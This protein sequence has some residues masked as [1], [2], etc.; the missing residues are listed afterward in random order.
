MSNQ[1]KGGLLLQS[2]ELLDFINHN[3]V[4]IRLLRDMLNKYLIGV[5]F[6]RP[7]ESNVNDVELNFHRVYLF[8][9]TLKARVPELVTKL[10][11]SFADG[12]ECHHN[13]CYFEFEQDLNRRNNRFSFGFVTKSALQLITVGS[14]DSE[15]K[16]MISGTV[17]DFGQGYGFQ[18]DQ[19]TLKLEP[20]PETFSFNLDAINSSSEDI[21]LPAVLVA[22]PCPPVWKP[23]NSISIIDNKNISTIPDF[24][25]HLQKAVEK[26]DPHGKFLD[27][28]EKWTKGLKKDG[29]INKKPSFKKR[30]EKVKN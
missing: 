17:A 8:E 26:P 16:I 13:D 29:I 25:Y 20:Y 6:K 5:V 18:G 28:F 27:E 1:T 24:Y 15:R 30:F 19:F 2:K 7:T 3:E 21:G 9:G 22:A 11:Y 23:L 14:D 4:R 12:R 10:G